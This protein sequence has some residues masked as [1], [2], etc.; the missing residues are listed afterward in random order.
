MELRNT[1]EIVQNIVQVARPWIAQGSP[2]TL[3][4]NCGTL[5]PSITTR[6]TN[7]A[8][9]HSRAESANE[10][11][12]ASVPSKVS[13]KS[14]ACPQK[15]NKIRSFGLQAPIQNLRHM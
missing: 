4:W 11:E 12:K 13:A 14:S 6:S 1:G 15:K 8:T 5:P 7:I 3:A 2:T 10:S 9:V